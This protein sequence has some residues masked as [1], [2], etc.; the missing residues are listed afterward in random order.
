MWREAIPAPAFSPDE[1]FAVFNPQIAYTIPRG[2]RDG[3]VDL[4]HNVTWPGRC[5][6]GTGGEFSSG[7]NAG[8][9]RASRNTE[10][11]PSREVSNVV[12]VVAF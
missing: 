11:S 3:D 8:A 2:E 4:S 12:S 9:G 10:P 6:W 7:E 1:N 5:R